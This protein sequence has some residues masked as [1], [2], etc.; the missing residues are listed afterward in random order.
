MTK[1]A[2][3]VIVSRASGSGKALR[4]W[5]DISALLKRTGIEYSEVI[6]EY[7]Y[8][9]IKLAAQAVKDG[10]RKIIV[11]GGDGAVHEVINGLFTQNEI[12]PGEITI[13]LI[14]VGSGNDW[15]RMHKIP[16]NYKA[17]VA[18]IAQADVFARYQDVA[19]VST[20]M[21]GKPY[22]RYMLNIGGLGFDS[23]VC[24]RFDLAKAQGKAQNHQYYK[25]LL[26]GFMF[27]HCMKFKVRIDG[28]LFYDGPAFSVALGIGKYCG[29]GMMQTPDAIIDDGLIN[30][31]VIGKVN[32]LTF[33]KKVPSLFK[34]TIY[35]LKEAHHT[36]GKH[37]EIE[38]TPYSFME[39]DGETV[40]RTPISVDVIPNAVKIVS[41]LK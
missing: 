14:P 6:T 32:K 30:V 3:K 35:Q 39:V 4:D 25:S 38:S 28:D 27:Y 29:G 2:W 34:G 26:G 41:C 8:H 37:I 36:M 13:A 18:M 20:I 7:S 22:C 31:T 5:P 23:E 10:F 19:R 12:S 17:A 11:I 16:K 1:T 15:A 33:L 9:A 40:G 24:R 21:D